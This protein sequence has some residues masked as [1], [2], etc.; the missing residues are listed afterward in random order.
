VTRQENGRWL[1]DVR[2]VNS[3]L[4]SQV[5]AR[6]VFVGAGGRAITLLQKSGIKEIRGY[7]GFPVGGQFLRCTN[8]DLVAEHR[9]KVYGKST[10]DAPPMAMP[11]LDSRVIDGKRGLMFGPFASFTPKFLKRGSLSDLVASIRPNNI[12]TMLQVAR[13]EFPLTKFLIRQVLQSHTDR[14]ETL[15]DFIPLAKPGDWELI[16]AGQRVQTMKPVPGKRGALV[17]GTEVVTSADG[18]IAGLLGASPG[19]SVS[20]SIMLDVMERCFP[21]EYP[22]WKERL[23]DLIPG[24]GLKL[25]DEPALY[26]EIRAFTDRELRLARQ[27]VP[28]TA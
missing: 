24:I 25:A 1:V 17:F 9:A 12:L 7:G 16:Q 21:A 3:G 8:P 22:A 26:E 6:F 27:D 18:S 15:R 13:D 2:D 11:H 19:A 23:R 5:S 28:A 20:P 4:V 14:V 10:L